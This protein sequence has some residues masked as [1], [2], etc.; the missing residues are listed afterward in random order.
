MREG[1][2]AFDGFS[3]P[4]ESVAAHWFVRQRSGEMEEEEQVLLEAWLA[5]DPYRRDC[6]SRFAL[7]LE[8][9]RDL[10][11]DP[12][13]AA[14]LKPGAH[15][16]PGGLGLGILRRPH[17]AAAA[18]ALVAAVAW[19]IFFRI[20][21]R[22]YTTAVGEQRVITLPDESE[23]I[24]NTDTSVS[25][26]LSR[27]KRTVEI[28]RGEAY[29]KVKRDASRPFEVLTGDGIARAVGTE[30]VVGALGSQTTVSVLKGRVFVAAL[31]DE[32]EAT[33]AAG[34]V[35]SPNRAIAKPDN[36]LRI[37]WRNGNGQ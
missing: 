15:A 11:D 2:S 1:K 22:H 8:L 3:T 36:H 34:P 6:F 10:K 26:F 33:Y 4:V 32:R 13:I 19:A 16:A 25:I 29:F 17:W 9:T 24:L 37:R 21:E 35:L 27:G 18:V 31:R 12:E 14:L 5:K 23:V 28:A 7:V 20:D 30:F